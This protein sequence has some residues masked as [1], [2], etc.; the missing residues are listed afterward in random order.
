MAVFFVNWTWIC[1][2]ENQKI[3]TRYRSYVLRQTWTRG[4]FYPKPVHLGGK[5]PKCF[6]QCLLWSFVHS[7]RPQKW[8]AGFHD[9]ARVWRYEMQ[10]MYCKFILYSFEGKAQSNIVKQKYVNSSLKGAVA[11]LCEWMQLN[12]GT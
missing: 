12:F 7:Q 9:F 10:R 1:H 5:Q 4:S 6:L 8:C 11:D 3:T 2:Q